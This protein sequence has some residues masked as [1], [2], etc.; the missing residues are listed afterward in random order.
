MSATVSATEHADAIFV[1][2]IER[3]ES[4]SRKF[5]PCARTQYLLALEPVMKALSEITYEQTVRVIPGT[6]E[7]DSEFGDVFIGADAALDTISDAEAELY[8]NYLHF[9][10]RDAAVSYAATM[11]PVLV[12]MNGVVSGSRT[13]R[14]TKIASW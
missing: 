12:A 7:M 9:R 10:E 5:G 13:I 3:S 2:I 11:N 14:Q 6:G 1:D 8:E 4:I